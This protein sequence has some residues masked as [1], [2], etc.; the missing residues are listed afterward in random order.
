[1]YD[2]S[3]YSTTGSSQTGIVVDYG[4]CVPLPALAVKMVFSAS[5][6]SECCPYRIFPYPGD[7]SGEIETVDC[8]NNTLFVVSSTAVVHRGDYWD[9]ICPYNEQPEIVA[10]DPPD[11]ASGVPTDA[12]LSWTLIDLDD[13]DVGSYYVYVDTIA[14]PAAGEETYNVA[15]VYDPGPLDPNRVYYWKV[16]SL[17]YYYA[18]G[19]GYTSR[20]TARSPVWSFT[21]GDPVRTVNRSWGA[22]KALYGH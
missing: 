1:L 10:P 9:C 14:E 18:P 17:E 15:S 16:E 12:Q 20:V 3:P 4:G 11:G 13:S 22:I 6:L 2:E 8:Q 19:E 5:G 7:I 21:T